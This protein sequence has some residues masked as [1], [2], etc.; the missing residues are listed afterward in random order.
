VVEAARAVA[1]RVADIDVRDAGELAGERV[2]DEARDIWVLVGVVAGGSLPQQSVACL[3]MTGAVKCRS[4]WARRGRQSP[5][6][7]QTA[8]ASNCTTSLGD[9]VGRR[10][11]AWRGARARTEI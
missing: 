4:L 2:E 10:A 5:I 1:H 8:P 3:V 6:Q 11:V 9:I 7:V